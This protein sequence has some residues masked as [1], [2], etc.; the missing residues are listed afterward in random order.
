MAVILDAVYAHAHPEFP[1]N[2]VYAAT[3]EPNPMMG[4]FMGEFFAQPGMDYRKEFTRDYFLA[5]N[6]HWLETYHVD[7]FRYDYVP[8]MYDG[9]AGDGYA[10]LAFDTYRL[11]QGMPRFTAPGGRSLIIQCA[12]HLPDAPGILRQTYSNTCWQNGLLDRAAAAAWGGSLTGLAHQFDPHLIGYPSEYSNPATGERLPAA[13]FQYIDSHDH[14]RFLNRIAPA[15]ADRDLLGEPLGDRSFFF[16]IQPYVIALYAAK[17]IPMLWQGQEFAENWSVPGSGIGRNLFGRPLHWEYFYDSEG[18]ALLRLHR[19]MG[20][21]RRDLRCLDA[22][23]FFYYYDIEDHRR[24]GVIA[25]RRR[26]EGPEQDAIVFLNFWNDD[27][28]VWLPFP[29]AGRWEEQIEKL[30]P[31]RRPSIDVGQDGEWQPV[32]VPS[33]YGCLY[34]R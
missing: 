18:R 28:T 31:D 24:R 16:R 13:P 25:F 1:Y 29:R 23:G 10:R 14:S 4:R 32:R 8:G 12:E 17:G 30:G 11:S 2:L 22:R 6:R 3:G 27:A 9:P 33:N 15:G 19:I 7:G 21:L 20:R 34:L 5:V 26:A